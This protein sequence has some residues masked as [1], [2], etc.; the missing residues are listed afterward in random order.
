[1]TA[2]EKLTKNQRKDIEKGV[3]LVTIEKLKSLDYGEDIELTEEVTLSHYC[4]DDVIVLNLTKEWEE[5]F[6]VLYNEDSNEII[7]EDL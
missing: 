2:F 7:F 5:V 3:D 1:M 6:Q 4:E